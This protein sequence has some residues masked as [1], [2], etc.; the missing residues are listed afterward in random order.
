VDVG[1]GKVALADG[2]VAVQGGEVRVSVGKVG[3]ASG[4]VA[5]GGGE[6]G[7]SVGKPTMVGGRV[8]V[9][10]TMMGEGGWLVSAPQATSS[11]PTSISR[12]GSRRRLAFILQL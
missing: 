12:T 9:G 3:V 2:W 4:W 8:A 1:V 5:V 11:P 10:K 7:V 6:V